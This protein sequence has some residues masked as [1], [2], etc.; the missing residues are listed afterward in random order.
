MANYTGAVRFSDG[1]MLMLSYQGT[2]DIARRQL[3]FAE[4]TV[5]YEQASHAVPGT[6][7]DEEQVDVFPYFMHGDRATSFP[8]RASK[9]LMLITGPVSVD[10]VTRLAQEH[11]FY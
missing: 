9:S 4:E 6:I 5:T 3:F 8:S 11:G 10:E 7:P 1:T 2:T